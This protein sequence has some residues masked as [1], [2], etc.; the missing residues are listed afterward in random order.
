MPHT[1]SVSMGIWVDAGARDETLAE[2]GLCH[3]IEHML[4]KGTPKRSAFQIAK[5]FD[6]I[7]GQS[8]AFTAMENT[9]FHARVMDTHLPVMADILLDMFLHSCFDEEECEKER[10]VVLQEVGM[11]EDS[12]EEYIHVLLNQAYWGDHVLGQSVLGPRENI[13]RF[14]EPVLKSFFKKFSHP[15]R[16]VVTAAGNLTHERF[17]ELVA[18]LLESIPAAGALPD[19]MAGSGV[20]EVLF[21]E[22]DLEQTHICLGLKG[23]AVTDPNRYALGMLNTVLGGNMSSRLF[24]EIRENRGLAYSVYSFVSSHADSGMFGAYAAVD[25][26]KA[27]DTI[28]LMAKELRRF[29]EEAIDPATLRNAQEY[30]KGN[31][32]L[33][34][35]SVDNQMARLA[36]NEFNFGRFVPLEEIMDDIDRVTAEEVKDLACALIQPEPSALAILGP[37]LDE[38]ACRAA[39]SL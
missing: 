2:S 29:K 18:P 25:P 17:L 16:I 23:G 7:G 39:L 24:Q 38:A 3:F 11:V 35:E 30:M 37:V 19:R 22:R 5:E 26:E 34:S 20:R 14:S 28:A 13:L 6:A 31:L 21:C 36:Q 1:R 15:E 9:C 8:N 4:F 27:P 12:P 10:P 32:L 33:A